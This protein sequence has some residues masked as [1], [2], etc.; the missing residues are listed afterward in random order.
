MF[1]VK[2]YMKRTEDATIV[3]NFDVLLTVNLSIFILVINQL[4]AQNL[5]YTPTGVMI[6][7]IV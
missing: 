6:P 2:Q 7:K 1:K 5:F 3:Q 4:E